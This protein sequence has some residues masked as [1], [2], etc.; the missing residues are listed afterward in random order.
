MDISTQHYGIY[1][2]DLQK[3]V[4]FY[5]SVL[6]FKTLFKADADEDGVPL[7]MA[8]IK[9]PNG[10]VIELL[11]LEGYNP[12]AAAGNDRNHIALRVSDMQSTVSAIKAAG[13]EMEVEP[14]DTALEF[15]RDIDKSVYVKCSDAGVTLKV[16]FFRGPSGERF[17]LMQDNIGGL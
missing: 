3:S 12:K 8:W 7:A 15:D 5:E 2:D 10:I 1:C 11:A 14:F 6:G 4:E 17:E 9:H 13:I 16:A